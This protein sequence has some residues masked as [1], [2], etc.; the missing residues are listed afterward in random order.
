[1]STATLSLGSVTVKFRLAGGAQPLILLPVHVNNRGPFDFILDT[2]A[3]TSLL[4]SELA[5]QLETKVI[6]SKEG[7]GA[8]GKVSVSLAKV[9]SISVG[10][11]KLRDVDVGI[12]DLAQIG[13]TMG[14]KF[15]GVLG[16]NFL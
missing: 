10:E 16:A 11:T 7:Q 5:K 9:D 14:V 13:K 3:G 4:S 12:V 2:G 15:A 1:M 8:G 6:G